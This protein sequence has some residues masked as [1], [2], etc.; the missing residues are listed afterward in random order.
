ML[1]TLTVPPD[2]VKVGAN[3]L[4]P[5]PLFVLPLRANVPEI[6]KV[7]IEEVIID[8]LEPLGATD[9]KPTFTEAQFIVPSPEIVAAVFDPAALFKV[10][11]PETVRVKLELTE[12]VA[13]AP[14]KVTELAAASAVT[15]MVWPLA[16]KTTSPATGAEA[17]AVP[18]DVAD[19]VAVEFQFPLTT[20]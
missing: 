16:I 8:V 12:R 1:P 9:V 18:P 15:V 10:S 14:V 17:P 5:V 19:Q 2:W 7:E 20:E 3:I 13:A 4:V 11:A 6:V